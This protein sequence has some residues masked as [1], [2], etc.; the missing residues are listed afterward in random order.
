M[1]LLEDGQNSTE[2]RKLISQQPDKFKYKSKKI[3]ARNKGF[4]QWFFNTEYFGKNAF[5]A[6]QKAIKTYN[7]QHFIKGITRREAEYY[8]TKVTPF[9]DVLLLKSSDDFA[10]QLTRLNV[11]AIQGV[12][13]KLLDIIETPSF[14]TE[15]KWILIQS[16][17]VEQQTISNELLVKGFSVVVNQNEE[18]IETNKNLKDQ[19]LRLEEQIA[20][21]TDELDH[22]RAEKRTKE[23]RKEARAKRKRLAK[24]DPITAE[25]YQQLIISVVGSDYVSARTRVAIVILA[26]TG[27]R[28]NELLPLKVEQL[29]TLIK[30]S[31]ISINRSKRGPSSHKAYLTPLGK[32]LIKKRQRDF[33]IIFSMKELDSYVFTSSSNHSKPLRRDTLTK[34]INYVM[35]NLA[36]ELPTQPNLTSHSFRI[37]FITQLWKDTNDIEFVRQAI[38]HIKVESTSSYVENLS[39]AERRIRMENIKSPEELIIDN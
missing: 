16:L 13:K 25:I 5:Q 29:T 37:G 27:I 31:W 11:E 17:V 23:E 12:K 7:E 30:S 6:I 9:K 3:K 34:E 20:I 22:A 38:G 39:D 33:E 19:V 28:I 8:N 14:S 32:T 10:N 24:R 35:R 36:N 4:R 1:N 18:I 2:L 15:K 21:L 26:I